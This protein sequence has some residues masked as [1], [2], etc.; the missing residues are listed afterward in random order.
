[1][2]DNLQVDSA[3]R[4][5]L[6]SGPRALLKADTWT[7]RNG[8]RPIRRDKPSECGTR[9]AG[10]LVRI[11]T[12]CAALTL[13]GGESHAQDKARGRSQVPAVRLEKGIL[14]S[15][16]ER[17]EPSAEPPT[18]GLD[19][20]CID[21]AIELGHIT[22]EH[23]VRFFYYNPAGDQY[24]ATAADWSFQPKQP[25]E[26]YHR[27]ARVRHRLPVRGEHA[28][29]L[30]GTWKVIVWLD[31]SYLVERRVELAMAPAPSDPPL[32]QGRKLY[33][34]LEYEAALE[35]LQAIVEAGPTK[36]LAA[37]AA[38]LTALCQYSLGQAHAMSQTLERLLELDPTFAVSPLEIAQLG[39][40]AVQTALDSVRTKRFPELYKKTTYS[41]EVELSK[42]EAPPVVQ[43]RWPLW[44]KLVIYGGIPVAALAAGA[45]LLPSGAT[46][47][48]IAPPNLTFEPM[49]TSKR[50]EF[51]F[52]CHG[53]LTFDV[54]ISGGAA[55][56]QA[57]FT[58]AKKGGTGLLS[59]PGLSSGD[60]GPE[61]IVMAT[62]TFAAPGSYMVRYPSLL[63]HHPSVQFVFA[64]M[65]AALV[66][67]DSGASGSFAGVV[68]GA[69]LP[70]SIE[71]LVRSEERIR[72]IVAG[73]VIQ[74]GCTQP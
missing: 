74:N 20:V 63:V 28:S 49:R 27:T 24:L 15:D 30:P 47:P 46:E 39:G 44:K 12:A 2:N 55:P 50:S 36:R 53:T 31:D 5:V 40:E 56:Y 65:D 51:G 13:V 57:I 37:E 26:G 23:R 33:L 8:P 71:D 17:P 73:D 64:T 67:R 54:V 70:D 21:A 59:A 72:R 29:L 62:Q 41:P 43:K 16:C 58:I 66:L 7:V 42:S 1:M 60:L 38:W 34:E 19:V 32:A 3:S 22:S 68:P 6:D 4:S 18:F 10:R 14:F 45:L 11:V 25:G 9:N 69:P 35:Q 61:E 52:L 48:E